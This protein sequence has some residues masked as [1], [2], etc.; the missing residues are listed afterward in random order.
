MTANSSI[1]PGRAT[2]YRSAAHPHHPAAGHPGPSPTAVGQRAAQ[3]SELV[4]SGGFAAE[5][6]GATVELGEAV[7]E[8]A[9][10]G[11]GV[12]VGAGHGQPT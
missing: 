10:V 3:A 1:D 6:G 2:R 7:E 11:E 9:G 12:G 5:E 4:V 8:W